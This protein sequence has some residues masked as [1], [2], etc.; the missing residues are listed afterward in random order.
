MPNS[1]SATLQQ[2]PASG[3]KDPLIFQPNTSNIALYF[4]GLHPEVLIFSSNMFL[5]K[6]LSVYDDDTHIHLDPST[7]AAN[8][9]IQLRFCSFF[10]IKLTV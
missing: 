8:F 6:H 1:G 7:F 5:Q 3:V 10:L 9:L 2:L 4:H